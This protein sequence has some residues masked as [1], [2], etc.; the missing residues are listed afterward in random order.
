[1]I[2]VNYKSSFLT[3][4]LFLP[5]NYHKKIGYLKSKWAVGTVRNLQTRGEEENLQHRQKPIYAEVNN[6][7]CIVLTKST[8]WLQ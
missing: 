8:V 4:L 3:S 7:A 2:S 5:L 6:E 1:M